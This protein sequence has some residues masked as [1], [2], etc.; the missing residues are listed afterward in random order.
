MVGV[1]A[2]LA[3]TLLYAVHNVLPALAGFPEPM[4]LVSNESSLHGVRHM[5]ASIATDLTGAVVSGMLGVAGVV[6]FGLLLR[7]RALALLSAVICFTP[8]VISGMFPGSAPRLDIAIGVGI[9]T[10]FI[11]TIDRAGLLSAI[12]ALFAHFVLLRAPITT[13][14]SSWHATVGIWHVCIVLAIGLGACYYA[15]SGRSAELTT[16]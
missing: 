1:S 6:G 14:F 3:M 13:D 12:A 8:V 16:S 10:V 2:G 11:L 9:I 5:L 7:S 15:R 4:P